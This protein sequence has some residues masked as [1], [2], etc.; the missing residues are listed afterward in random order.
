[1]RIKKRKFGF[2]ANIPLWNIAIAMLAM[3]NRSDR[4]LIQAYPESGD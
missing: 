2:Y 1:M 3:P 4:F